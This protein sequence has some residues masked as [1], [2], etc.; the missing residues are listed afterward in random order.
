MYRHLKAL[1][2]HVSVRKKYIGSAFFYF[3]FC[4]PSD[5]SKIY[6]TDKIKIPIIYFL[7]PMGGFIVLKKVRNEELFSIKYV[8]KKRKCQFYF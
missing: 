7:F 6:P 3:S 2:Y 8:K 5:P 1:P 4:V